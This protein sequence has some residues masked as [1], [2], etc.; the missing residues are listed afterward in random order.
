MPYILEY[1]FLALSDLATK[2][3]LLRFYYTCRL[4]RLAQATVGTNLLRRYCTGTTAWQKNNIE[5]V[6][7]TADAA[8]IQPSRSYYLPRGCL[9]AKERR[10][11]WGKYRCCSAI[12]EA[13]CFTVSIFLVKIP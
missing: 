2:G 13:T 5:R 7:T 6:H 3:G 9:R 1:P 12:E 4:P 8:I 11:T 10:P